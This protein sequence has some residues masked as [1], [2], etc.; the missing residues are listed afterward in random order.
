MTDTIPSA[1]P[2]GDSVRTAP[3]G[4]TF[5]REYQSIT[6]DRWRD[7]QAA[8]GEVIEVRTQ[9]GSYATGYG[10]RPHTEATRPWTNDEAD[11]HA[12]QELGQ[13]R[14]RRQQRNQEV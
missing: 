10:V 2:I 3:V 7:Y 14:W 9:C 11:A 5:T 13:R 12:S 1:E 8:D 4:V 6:G